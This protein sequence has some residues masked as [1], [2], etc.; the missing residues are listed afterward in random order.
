M[1]LPY[2]TEGQ[3][4]KAIREVTPSPFKSFNKID[5]YAY[6]LEY[7]YLDYAFAFKYFKENKV[8]IPNFGCTSVRSGNFFGR[9]FD[10]FYNNDCDFIIRTNGNGRI[11][12][13]GVSGSVG[14]LNKEDVAKGRVDSKYYKLIPFYILD[15][16]NDAGV[17]I[18]SNVVPQDKGRVIKTQCTEN[19]EY[20]M[21]LLMFPRFVLDK[22]TTALD[23]CE[24]A[25]KHISFFQTDFAG[26]YGY[27][28]HFMIGDSEHTYVLEII[29]NKVEYKEFNIM[30][31]FHV[32]GTIFN[33]DGKVYT[34]ET[35]DDTHNAIDT[36]KITKHGCGLERHNV[37]VDNIDSAD[38][39][40][41]MVNLMHNLLNYNKSY[42]LNSNRWYTEFVGTTPSRDYTVITSKDTYD[43]YVMPIV[44]E[45]FDNRDRDETPQ[46]IWHTTHT[47]VYD[48]QN[49]KLYFYSSSEDN[50]EHVFN[51][52]KYY[53]SEEI[54]ALLSN[55]NK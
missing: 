16:L 7:D 14:A 24:Y 36:N 48:L 28:I 15:G 55:L 35:Q 37:A 49:K 11:P 8:E 1:G 33:N 17:F 34:P 30:T 21:F 43:E 27:D 5:D 9:N 32:N 18:N 19:E 41:G 3:L 53:T 40:E 2:V 13:I 4:A 46:T 23:A 29:D 26:K 44:K 22:F 20:E 54:D 10:W 31:N 25:K 45:K 38:T 50:V 51:F 42:T 39:K 6:D 47:S 52:K 12:S